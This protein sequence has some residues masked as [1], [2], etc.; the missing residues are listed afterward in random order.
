MKPVLG[1]QVPVTLKHGLYL[2][3]ASRALEVLCE[4]GPARTVALVGHNPG[5]EDLLH[6]LT[7]KPE[8]L[9]T[10]NAALLESGAESWRGALAGP[11]SLR[12]VLRPRVP[13]I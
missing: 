7:G 12:T 8:R 11:W 2:A 10:C 9:T 1:A 13:R 6:R 4:A 5:W 3:G